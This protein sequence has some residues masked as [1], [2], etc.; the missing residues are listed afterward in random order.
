[1]MMAAAAFMECFLYTGTVL[2]ASHTPRVGGRPRLARRAALCVLSSR[3]TR[4]LRPP[5]DGELGP[6]GPD[7]TS[8]RKGRARN[9]L[10]IAQERPR[11]GYRHP[12][13]LDP[14]AFSRYPGARKGAWSPACEA[15]RDPRKPPPGEGLR[16]SGLLVT[17]S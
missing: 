17:L 10:V 15:G 4:P 11:G 14:A 3:Q 2:W 13:T 1:M 5:A 6:R 12:R 16:E 9:G 8:S 7:V